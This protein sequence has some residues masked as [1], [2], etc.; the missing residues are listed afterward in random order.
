MGPWT[1]AWLC[2]PQLPS[3]RAKTGRTAHVFA[4]QGGTRRIFGLDAQIADRNRS[5]LEVKSANEIKTKIAVFLVL[6]S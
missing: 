3:T 1:F 5:A 2:S 6:V 4:A